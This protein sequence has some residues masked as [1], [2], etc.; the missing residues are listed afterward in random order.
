MAISV[1]PCGQ[2]S[3]I[4]YNLTS[5]KDISAEISIYDLSG[6]RIFVDDIK[7]KK[8]LNN[9]SV[10][11]GLTLDPKI[12]NVVIKFIDSDCPPLYF[13]LITTNFKDDDPPKSFKNCDNN[14][15][16][17]GFDPI[18]GKYIPSWVGTNQDSSLSIKS[19]SFSS[20]ENDYSD[21]QSY[22]DIPYAVAPIT[23][24]RIDQEKKH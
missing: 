20:K 15:I 2:C 10:S 6:S 17:I 13:N 1:H 19:V 24:I 9:E 18:T 3:E 8:G 23:D 11:L 5:P 4:T 14:I 7:I 22:A 21:M 12:Y 16:A